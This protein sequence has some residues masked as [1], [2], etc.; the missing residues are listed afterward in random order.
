M[1]GAEKLKQM[2]DSGEF[3]EMVARRFCPTS[4]DIPKGNEN[5][6]R[7]S[8]HNQEVCQACWR[9]ALESDVK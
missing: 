5:C 3:A 9:K 1:T 8:T 2:I 6:S 7:W 4:V